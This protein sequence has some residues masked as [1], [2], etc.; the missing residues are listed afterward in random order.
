MVA[1]VVVRAVKRSR[2]V[3]RRL[4]LGRRPRQ[5][6]LRK[7]GGGGGAEG[8]SAAGEAEEEEEEEEEEAVAHLRDIETTLEALG[9]QPDRRRMPLRNDF[10]I[11]HCQVKR[12][13]RRN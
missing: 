10:F 5:D 1:V 3:A 13:R 8:A 7:R 11:S 9:L 2:S 4:A 6:A 12:K